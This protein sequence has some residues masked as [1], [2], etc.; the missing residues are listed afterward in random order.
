MMTERQ[1][2]DMMMIFVL[3]FAVDHLW[4]KLAFMSRA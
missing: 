3:D 4:K 2:E 1:D